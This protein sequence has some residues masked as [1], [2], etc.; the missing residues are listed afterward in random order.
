MSESKACLY[1]HHQLLKCV[2]DTVFRKSRTDRCFLDVTLWGVR[3]SL[4]IIPSS[5]HAFAMSLPVKRSV[6]VLKTCSRRALREKEKRKE[7]I[8]K[9]LPLGLVLASLLDLAPELLCQCVS[10]WGCVIPYTH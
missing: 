7:E 4:K 2:Y 9:C 5:I 8:N 10:C 6:S 1:A 3:N